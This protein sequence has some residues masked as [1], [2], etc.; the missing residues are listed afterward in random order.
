ML[1]NRNYEIEKK[2]IREVKNSA[3]QSLATVKRG[4]TTIEAAVYLGVS[5]SLLRQL[6]MKSSHDTGPEYVKVRGKIVYLKEQLDD[7]LDEF[8]VV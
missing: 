6:R 4:F 8:K 7:W 5:D 2:R 1:E 3:T